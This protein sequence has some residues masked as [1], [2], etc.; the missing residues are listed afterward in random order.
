LTDTSNYG[1]FQEYQTSTSFIGNFAL[2]F[3]ITFISLMLI[4]FLLKTLIKIRN[5][6]H[7]T[8][9]KKKTTKDSHDTNNIP[10]NLIDLLI[11]KSQNCLLFVSLHI[12]SLLFKEPRSHLAS[13]DFLEV[14]VETIFLAATSA[15][16]WATFIEEL[17]SQQKRNKV[18][19]LSLFIQQLH[20]LIYVFVAIFIGQLFSSKLQ[21]ILVFLIFT[22]WVV[23][24]YYLQFGAHYSITWRNILREDDFLVQLFAQATLLALAIYQLFELIPTADYLQV[25]LFINKV[26]T[27]LIILVLYIIKFLVRRKN[28]TKNRTNKLK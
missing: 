4:D 23:T 1:T 28:I 16:Y 19:L 7:K 13:L 26:G 14:V 24:F 20:Q 27:I 21:A 9:E 11:A 18:K 2:P 15:A 3:V 6:F 17:R 8:K 5:H 12:Y 10:K 25:M 22:S